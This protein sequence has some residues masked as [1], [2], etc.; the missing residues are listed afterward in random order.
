M[1]KT[2]KRTVKRT[3]LILAFL[4][5]SASTCFLAYLHFFA[6]ADRDLS[7]EW[8][9]YL[10]MTEQAAVTAA[11]WLQDMEAVSVSL[12]DMESYMQDLTV[13]VDL[14]MEQT[15]RFEGT[16]RCSVLPESYSA[17]NEAAYEAFAAAFRDLLTERLRM[18]GY[19]GGTDREA[20]E[21]LITETFGMS[22]VS[23]LMSCGPALLPSLEEMQAGYDGS[24]VY[25]TADGILTRRF[26]SG[27]NAATKTERYIRKDFN[28]ILYEENGSVSA[29]LFSGYYPV[30]Y[31]LIQTQ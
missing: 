25:E 31:T 19:T 13:Q 24:G 4:I 18:A 22:T 28:L 29:G 8:R 5:L 12:E 20:V 30:V 17:C 7:G 15:A 3:V 16:F 23:Y 21:A 11:C 27:Q 1:R 9:A 2:V 10:D 14:T 6:S 26:D